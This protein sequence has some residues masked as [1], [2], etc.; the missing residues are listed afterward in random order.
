[1]FFTKLYFYLFYQFILSIYLHTKFP[2]FTMV[3]LTSTFST[4]AALA[5]AGT[6]VAHPSSHSPAEVAKRA[7]FQSIARRSLANCQNKLR[8]RGGV[9]ERSMARRAAFAERAR[10]ERGLSNTTP[11]LRPRKRDLDTILATSH[12]SNETG[13]T[14]DSDPFDGNSSCVLAPEVTQGP[15]RR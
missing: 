6:V 1:M 8:A 5:V 2:F 15:Y 3:K 14:T 9:A 10:K 4:I 13:L 11:F 12:A 7:E